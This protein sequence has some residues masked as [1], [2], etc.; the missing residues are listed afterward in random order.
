VDR[1]YIDLI[2]FKYIYNQYG[3]VNELLNIGK[4]LEKRCLCF[5]TNYYP[6]INL[7]GDRVKYLVKHLGIRGVRCIFDYP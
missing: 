6:G 7:F 2:Y 3:N 5:L 1:L 4:N